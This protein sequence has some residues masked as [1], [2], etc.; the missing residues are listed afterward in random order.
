MT[1]LKIPTKVL[2]AFPIFMLATAPYVITLNYAL[3]KYSHSNPPRLSSDVSWFVT[4]MKPLNNWSGFFL[5]FA[6]RASQ[7]IYLSN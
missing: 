1:H 2:C 3:T 7:Y 6:D 5:R 4:L